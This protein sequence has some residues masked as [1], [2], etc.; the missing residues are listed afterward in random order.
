MSVREVTVETER[1]EGFVWWR[2]KKNLWGAR[3]GE[4]QYQE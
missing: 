4:K 3:G 2:E 1:E